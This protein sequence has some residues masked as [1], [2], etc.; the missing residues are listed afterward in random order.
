[1]LG[2][3][4]LTWM[5]SAATAAL[6]TSSAFAATV[7]CSPEVE[8][9][10][11]GASYT[12]PPGDCRAMCS[13]FLAARLSGLPVNNVYFDGDVPATCDA[14]QPWSSANVRHYVF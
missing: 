5:L 2:K 11:P 12:I 10:A 3:K 1:M 13:T 7:V 6:G 4:V 9:N 14:W 8:W